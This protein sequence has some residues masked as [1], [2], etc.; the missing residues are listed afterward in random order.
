[1]SIGNQALVDKQAQ[2]QSL[3]SDLMAVAEHQDQVAFSRLF[4][5]FVPLIQSFIR[6]K[7]PGASTVASEVAQEVMI[8][9][10]QKA[11][12]YK[13]ELASPMTWVYTLARNARIDYLRKNGRH[14]SNID[15]EYV[16][17]T[18]ESDDDGPFQA[19]QKQKAKQQ[20]HDNLQHLSADQRQVIYKV[21]MEG[22]THDQVAIDLQIPLGTVK[23]RIRLA[24][25]RL[26][27]V[28]KR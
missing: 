26:A 7:Q 27:V 25:K 6:A 10:W 3:I 14:E 21:Y 23:S 12:T 13:P 16:W 28:I 9:V 19:A 24:L 20:V 2:Q 11:H 15:P 5:H 1:M 8:K 18:M 22:K 4:D 17:E